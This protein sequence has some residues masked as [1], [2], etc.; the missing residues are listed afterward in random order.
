MPTTEDQLTAL[1]GKV[2]DELRL[3]TTATPEQIEQ[4]TALLGE[5][6]S[7]LSDSDAR[8]VAEFIAPQAAFLSDTI[9]T[10]STDLKVAQAFIAQRG[11]RREYR[12]FAAKE[13][14]L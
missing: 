14:G 11:L 12:D 10:M 5:H 4:W 7:G 9:A 2:L 3:S 8:R 13:A 1:V 6:L